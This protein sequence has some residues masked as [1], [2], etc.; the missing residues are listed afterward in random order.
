MKAQA[1]V[2][3]FVIAAMV[4]M[5]LI[6]VWIYI[7]TTQ[8]SASQELNLA[9]AKNAVKQFSDASSLVNSQGYP[10]KIKLDIFIPDGLTNVT[11]VDRTII[12]RMNIN[13]QITDIWYESNAQMQGVDEI[14]LQE[15]YYTFDFA[16]FDSYVQINRTV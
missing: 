7:V 5:F 4:L 3:Y 16:S 9:Y 10:A 12:F 15:G 6:P 1:A 2:E 11:I 8:Q 14:P 13:D